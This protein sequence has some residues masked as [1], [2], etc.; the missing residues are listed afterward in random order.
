MNL[1]TESKTAAADT[2]IRK[3]MFDRTFDDTSGPVH[4]ARDRR[5]V[6]LT[7]EQLETLKKEARDAGFAA[8][9]AAAAEDQAKH[10]N[11][12][13]DKVSTLVGHLLAEAE[14]RRPQ[15]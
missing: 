12:T 6:T 1:S 13:V 7:Y 3:F 8:G 15:Q 4:H 5:P 10:L 2:A 11:A 14:A 9:R